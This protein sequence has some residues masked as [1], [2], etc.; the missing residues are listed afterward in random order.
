MLLKPRQE[1][2]SISVHAVNMLDP[3]VGLRLSVSIR[4]CTVQLGY[5]SFVG[6]RPGASIS[7][8]WGL[9]SS[10]PSVRASRHNVRSAACV[11]PWWS[12]MS[13]IAPLLSYSRRLC[14]VH[15]SWMNF[16]CSPRERC[17]SDRLLCVGVNT[18]SDI[19]SFI[20]QNVH[21]QRT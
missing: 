20:H 5:R 9:A 17:C 14:A 4:H 15:A 7:T 3:P 21:W 11:R 8:P 19:Y 6:R 2:L 12:A 1:F 13:T 10:W 18:Q 16:V